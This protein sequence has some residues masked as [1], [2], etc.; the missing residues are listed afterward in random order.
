MTIRIIALTG[1]MMSGK[2]TVAKYLVEQHD[3]V[4]VK[5]AEPLKW[6]LQSIGLGME[7]IEGNKKE[8][9]MTLLSEN[10]PRFAMQTL[11]QEW[12]RDIMGENF[13]VNIWKDRVKHLLAQG[14]YD[15]VTDDC[16][17]LNEQQAVAEMGGS[18]WK[19][20]RPHSQSTLLTEMSQEHRSETAMEEIEVN[21]IIQN[22]KDIHNLEWIVGSL[23]QENFN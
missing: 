9:P 13:W 16:R 2:S 19:V 18:V 5:F 3:F 12:G 21:E 4:L 10:T 8:L 1:N 15:I 6:M 7:E 11:G 14:Y 20:V 23:M 17:Y 22:T